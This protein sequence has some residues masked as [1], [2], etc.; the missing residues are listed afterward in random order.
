MAR[1]SA[2]EGTRLI[3]YPGLSGTDG[4]LSRQ[5]F[6]GY[7]RGIPG[8]LIQVVTFRDSQSL[9]SSRVEGHDPWPNWEA[10]FCG[11]GN[12]LAVEHSGLSPIFQR[13]LFMSHP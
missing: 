5:D 11:Y 9:T 7:T 10:F 8:K 12:W 2:E 13:K 6:L 3:N 1:T 4:V